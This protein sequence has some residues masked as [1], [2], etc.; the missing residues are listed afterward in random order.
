MS[1]EQSK[2]VCGVIYVA[3]GEKFIKEA[4][5]SLASLRKSNPGVPAMLLTDAPI[6]NPEKWDK[7][8][9]DESLSALTTTGKSCKAKLYMDRAPWDRCLYID[10]DT[11][12]VGDLGPGFALLDRFE[13]AAEQM[14]GGHHYTVPGVPP[15]YPEISGGVLFWKPTENVK[16]FFRRWRELFDEYDQADQARTWDQKSLRVAMWQS[17]VRFVRMPTTFNLMAYY[18]AAIEREV[19][20]VH[21]RSFE[22][23]RRLHERLSKTTVFRAYVPGLGEMHHPQNMSWG[24]CLWIV[25]RILAWKMMGL[26]K[27]LIRKK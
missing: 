22:N 14:A 10:T 6:A 23:L 5:I 12:V 18:P 11:L 4:E 3:S 21:G 19:V 1:T 17:D 15:S 25:W 20:I 27:P 2:P 7:V 16:A 24:D 8:E 26:V 9:V 13:F